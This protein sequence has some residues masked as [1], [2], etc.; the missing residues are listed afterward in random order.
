M[1][2]LCRSLSGFF[3][4]F[5][6]SHSFNFLLFFFS[7]PFF[8]FSTIMDYYIHFRA[9]ALVQVPVCRLLQVGL[10]YDTFPSGSLII[11]VGD[12]SRIGLGLLKCLLLV[13]LLSRGGEYFQ[14]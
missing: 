12:R 11:L 4:I 8:V 3:V 6:I 13:G 14:K 5:L 2:T 9:W 7:F 1:L 10:L